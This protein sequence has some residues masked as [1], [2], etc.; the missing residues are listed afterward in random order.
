MNFSDIGDQESDRELGLGAA[1]GRLRMSSAPMVDQAN[2]P[3]QWSIKL[4]LPP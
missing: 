2:P 1:F 4:I 3:L